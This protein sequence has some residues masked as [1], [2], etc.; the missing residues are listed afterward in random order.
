MDFLASSLGFGGSVPRLTTC[1]PESIIFPKLT[2]AEFLAVEAH[3]IVN[4]STSTPQAFAI[5]KDYPSGT[6]PQTFCNITVTHTHP[7][8]HDRIHTYIWLPLPLPNGGIDG[9]DTIVVGVPWNGVMMSLGGGGF[10][11]SLG[12]W[13]HASAVSEGYA[14]VSTDGGHT[15]EKLGDPSTWALVSEGNV[16]LYALQNFA[17]VSLRDAA[18]IGKHLLRRLLHGRAPGRPAG[19]ALAQRWPGL[20]DGYLAG[21]PALYWDRFLVA[22]LYPHAVMNELGYVPPACELHEFSRRALRHCDGLDGVEDGVISEPELCAASF[23]PRALAGDE[24]VCEDEAAVAAGKTKL[25]LTEKGARVAQAVWEGWYDE[26]ETGADEGGERTL[27]WPGLGHQAAI[28][29]DIKWISTTCDFEQNPPR[30]K[31]RA[32]GLFTQWL[33]Y[34]VRRTH[35]PV[36]E[37]TL[38]VA[39]LKRALHTSRQWYGSVLGT[40]DADLLELRASGAKLL[41]WHGLADETIPYAQ[42]QTYYEAVVAAAAAATS[43]SSYHDNDV[44]V[45]DDYLRYFEAPGVGHCGLGGFGFR[46]QGLVD[47]LRAWV[48]EG[49]APEVLPAR[50]M[51]ANSPPHGDD[52]D[53]DDD[54]NN[55]KNGGS[56]MRRMLCKYPKRAKYNG[57]GD[58]AKAESFW[59]ETTLQ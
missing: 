42:T 48:E 19:P 37:S 26:D 30:C 16:D 45:V 24:F 12:I 17:S 31:S 27:V 39:G 28:E 55:N 18:V 32:L 35:E 53:D 10:Q 58:V 40:D 43:P 50:M 13:N 14:A 23:D 41:L 29:G 8:Q 25:K 15:M 1:Q 49:K 57:K 3:A 4:Y 47:A 34:F 22:A 6:P 9:G 44:D 33:Q 38:T 7:G 5:V 11:T 51:V 56:D 54:N 52:A 20:H 21:A 59:C 36:G 46:P 2:G